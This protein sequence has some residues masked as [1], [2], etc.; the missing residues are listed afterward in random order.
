M[1]T[2]KSDQE[3]QHRVL[4]DLARDT[5]LVPGEIAVSVREGVVTLSGYVRTYA[6]KCEA[7]EVALRSSGVNALADDVRVRVPAAFHPSDSDMAGTLLRIVS[8]D[9]HIPVGAVHITVQN[10]WVTLTGRV[11]R[12]DQR[13]AIERAART[14][15]GFTGL[16]NLLEA[17]PQPPD[18]GHQQPVQPTPNGVAASTPALRNQT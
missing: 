18:T 7:L 15:H 9:L 16:S 14:L 4:D 3:L 8:D 13:T 5:R 11:A 12:R 2:S 6:E 10:G 1:S 17:G